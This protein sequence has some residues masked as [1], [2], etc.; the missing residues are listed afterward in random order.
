MTTSTIQSVNLLPIYFQTDKNS[1]FLSSSIDQLIQPAQIERISGFIGSKLSPT[2][3]S[4]ADNYI[5]DVLEIRKDYQ[6]NPALIVYDEL[7]NIQRA[8]SIDDLTNSISIQSGLS[9]DFDKL[10]SS[11]T[12]SYNPHINWDKFTS[13]QKYYWL[14][15]GPATI[16]IG[17]INN[18]INVDVDIIGRAEY[19]FT[20]VTTTGTTATQALSNGMKIQFTSDI[21]SQKHQGKI[22]FVEGVGSSIVL[23]DY[24]RLGVNGLIKN[25]FFNKF[26]A[27]NFD[28]YGYDSVSAIPINPEYITI[29]RASGDLNPWTRYNRW[30]H[31]D[32]ITISATVN[33][34]IPVYPASERAQRPIVEFNAGL[35]LYNFGTVGISKVDIIDTDTID[36]FSSIEGSEG[37]YIDGILLEKGNRIIFNADKNQQVRGNI[38]VVNFAKVNDVYR[39]QLLLDTTPSVE[40]AVVISNGVANKGTSWHFNGHHWVVLQQHTTLNHFPLFDLFD[41][42]GT[43]YVNKQHKRGT[44]RTTSVIHK[45]RKQFYQTNK[46]H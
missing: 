30:F 46:D 42:I 14:P 40:S 21:V 8:I 26:D 15:T 12:Y 4:T 3:N 18:F 28:Q 23:V 1:K 33:G 5:S 10:Y 39:I 11:P 27:H 7:N 13:Y 17:S 38:Y 34:L 2:Y 32:I 44:L 24:D 35:K 36:A 29:N 31:Q 41:K 43:I 6:F 9:A 37:Y 19:S 45:K 16:V 22:Y 20:Y 25:N